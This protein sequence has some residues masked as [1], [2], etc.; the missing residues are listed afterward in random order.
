MKLILIAAVS[1][2]GV[3]GKAD[4]LPWYIPEDLKHFKQMTTG[5]AC[6]MG[7]R[8]F[9]SIMNRLKK[10]LPERESIVVSRQT[11]WQPP[12]GVKVFHSLEEALKYL[13]HHKEVMVIGGGQVYSQTIDKADKLIL[14]EV[15]KEIDGDVLFPKFDKSLWNEV[16]RED[17]P[18]FS[19]V[20]YEKNEQ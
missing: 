13:E 15:H 9:D 8:T 1:K 16:F 12:E 19:F 18:E 3:I 10:P 17:H 20:E 4:A 11:D 7:K 5:K 6:L 2:N 14:T